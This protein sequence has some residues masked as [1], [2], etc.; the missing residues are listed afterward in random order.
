MY[1]REQGQWMAFARLSEIDNANEF[2]F[3]LQ[4]GASEPEYDDK[5]GVLS[6]SYFTH[7]GMFA[8]IPGYDPEKD[9]MPSYE[10][11]VAAVET[12]FKRTTNLSGL[13]EK[14]GLHTPEGKLDVRKSSV[15]GHLLAQFTLDPELPYGEWT[16]ANPD[17]DGAPQATRAAT[18][19]ASTTTASP[20]ARTITPRR[21]MHLPVGS[22]ALWPFLNNFF[23]VEFACAPRQ[24]VPPQGPDHDDERR[25]GGSF[26]VAPG[27]TYWAPRGLR[28]RACFNYI[29]TIIHHKPFLTLLK[30]NYEKNL[31]RAE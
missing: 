14:V 27:S 11:Q 5:L 31:G 22:V 25:P 20:R 16:E 17:A 3:G 9:P 4:E 10:A 19:M 24:A 2:L 1:A 23:S 12:Q 8:N 29:R 6:A 13:Y 7:A 18:R 28:I 21:W 26:Y 15:Y 30:G